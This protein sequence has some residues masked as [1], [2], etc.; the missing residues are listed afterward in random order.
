MA[1][2]SLFHCCRRFAELTTQDFELRSTK[3]CGGGPAV[4]SSGN[5]PIPAPS[6]LFSRES[7]A[8]NFVGHERT[9]KKNGG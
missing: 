8:L 7:A 2:Q 5:G 4:N 9:Q 1:V 3:G 6:K